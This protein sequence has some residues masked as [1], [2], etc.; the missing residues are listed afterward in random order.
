MRR[1]ESQLLRS[2]KGAPRQRLIIEKRGELVCEEYEKHE[3][4]LRLTENNCKDAE[5][6]KGLDRLAQDDDLYRAI[7]VMTAGRTK[8]RRRRP[9]PQTEA[10]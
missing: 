4:C 5:P 3:Y 9:G 10:S 7:Q 1:G 2:R 8:V 6:S